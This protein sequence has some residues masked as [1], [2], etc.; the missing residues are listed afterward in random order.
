MNFAYVGIEIG[1]ISGNE[2][3]PSSQLKPC[4]VASNKHVR[5]GV[6]MQGLHPPP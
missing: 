3:G 1:P 2:R 6:D 4:Y 5:S